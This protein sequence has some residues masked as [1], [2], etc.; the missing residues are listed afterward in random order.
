[1]DFHFKQLMRWWGKR[2]GEYELIKGDFLDQLHVEKLN[3]A[4]LI[5]VNNLCFGP[6]ID[7]QLEGYLYSVAKSLKF[8]LIHRL[9]RTFCS[10]QRWYSYYI[11]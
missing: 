7:L 3:S 5:F 6:T 9:Y 10:T 2:Y 1:M 4:N 8:V 11:I